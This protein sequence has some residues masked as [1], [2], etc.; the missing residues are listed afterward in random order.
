[1]AA[2]AAD[3]AAELLAPALLLVTVPEPPTAGTLMVG[4]VYRPS[5][6]DTPVADVDPPANVYPFDRVTVMDAPVVGVPSVV[7][8]TYAPVIVE[9]AVPE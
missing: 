3:K 7:A 5:V 9:H 1:M 4:S 8:V 2:E 6:P